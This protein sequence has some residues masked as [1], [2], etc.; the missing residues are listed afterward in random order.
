MQ[1]CQSAAESR[2]K[3][4]PIMPQLQTL[5]ARAISPKSREGSNELG[6]AC[7]FVSVDP[8]PKLGASSLCSTR[9]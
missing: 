8:E 4:G 1:P 5:Q 7:Q 9:A 3:Y 2:R 6:V